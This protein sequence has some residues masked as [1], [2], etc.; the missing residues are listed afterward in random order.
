[1]ITRVK[2][3]SDG[4]MFNQMMNDNPKLKRMLDEIREDND[5]TP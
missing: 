3:V 1:M 2:A 5:K 4:M